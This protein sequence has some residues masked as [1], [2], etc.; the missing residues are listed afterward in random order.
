[1]PWQLWHDASLKITRVKNSG[2]TSIEAF[3]EIHISFLG[4]THKLF[5]KYIEAFQEIHINF[6]GLHYSR[7]QRHFCFWQRHVRCEG[8]NNSSFCQNLLHFHIHHSYFVP[9]VH[10]YEN[11]YDYDDCSFEMKH[12]NTIWNYFE[13]YFAK[14]VQQDIWDLKWPLV[15]QFTS[16]LPLHIS[17]TL[18]CTREQFEFSKIHQSSPVSETV[19]DPGLWQGQDVP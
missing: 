19:E 3:Q 7:L 9:H 8:E 4:N 15:V 14:F 17:W 6:S 2:N 10:I 12:T 13:L 5:R 16:K 11:I 1:M 18:Y